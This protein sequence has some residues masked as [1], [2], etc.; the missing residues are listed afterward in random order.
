MTTGLKR[1][2]KKNLE[3]V[4]RPRLK[5]RRAKQDS[6]KQQKFL[7]R[8]IWNTTIE[9]ES[10]AVKNPIKDQTSLKNDDWKEK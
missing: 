3:E 10:K 5:K 6:E 7:E 9:R 8:R 4:E 1:K 2:A